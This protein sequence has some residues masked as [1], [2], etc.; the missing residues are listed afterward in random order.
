MEKMASRISS[1]RRTERRAQRGFTLSEIIIGMTISSFLMLGVLTTF[2]LMG[3]TSANIQNYSELEAS[4]RKALEFFGREVHN[5]CDVPSWTGTSVTL[6]IPDTTDAPKG[7]GTG[8]Y[9]V[10]YAFDTTNKK[11]TRTVGS[12]TETLLTGVNLV[13]GSTAFLNY[14]RYVSQTSYPLGQ[15]YFDGFTTNTA[16]NVRELKQIEV[17]FVLQRTSQT[18]TA[19]TNKVLSARFILR[20]K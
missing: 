14:Y 2:L 16:T 13:T 12:T 6:T 8:S 3:R 11:L 20:N 5:A 1:T 9:T 7:T 18:V 15:G 19:A 10:T 17:S 4:A